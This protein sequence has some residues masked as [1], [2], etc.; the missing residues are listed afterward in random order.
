LDLFVPDSKS[1][2]RQSDKWTDRGN[3]IRNLASYRRPHYTAFL[4]RRIKQQLSVQPVQKNAQLL[5][6]RVKQ[7]GRKLLLGVTGDG[8]SASNWLVNS[9]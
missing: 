2:M 4:K 5:T 1:G 7:P 9:V 6:G 8:L 3:V